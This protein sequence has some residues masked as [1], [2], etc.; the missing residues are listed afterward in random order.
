M[1]NY[2]IHSSQY[3]ENYKEIKI[4]P[5]SISIISPNSRLHVFSDG[6]DVTTDELNAF[7]NEVMKEDAKALFYTLP[8]S[9]GIGTLL[10]MWHSLYTDDV[11]K[12]VLHRHRV[13]TYEQ[14]AP[15]VDS[16][17]AVTDTLIKI[18]KEHLATHVL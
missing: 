6:E 8:T 11:I 18:H 15:F 9:Q 14:I 4:H 7:M 16:R 2:L 10:I 1:S 17:K 13:L 3:V 5:K 12:F